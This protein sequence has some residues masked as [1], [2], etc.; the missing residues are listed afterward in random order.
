MDNDRVPDDTNDK[1]AQ[2]SAPADIRDEIISKARQSD[3]TGENVSDFAPPVPERDG[4]STIA[5]P[6]VS[7]WE[8]RF[9]L[10]GPDIRDMAT[11]CRQL[12]TLLDVGIP[13]LQA[14]TILTQRTTHPRLQKVIAAVARRV[15]EGGTLSSALREH[16][17]VFSFLFI[18]VIEV[19][20]SAGILEASAR[21]LAEILE[22]KARTR[23]RVVS[24]MMY[25]LAALSVCFA[26]IMLIVVW[27]V[28]R[29][30][31]IYKQLGDAPLPDATQR[32]IAISDFA[33]DYPLLY[34]P[35][36]I[37]AAVGLYIW[38]RTPS[39]K[40]AFDWLSLTAPI[41]SGVS[42]KVN[43]AR[44][45]RS[46]GSLVAAG[47]SL[48]EALEIT[49][50]SSEN[51]LMARRLR[52]VHDTLEQGGQLEEPLRQDAVIPPM[53]TDMIVIG[54]E[55]GAIDEMLLRVADIYDEEVDETLKGLTSIIEPALIVMLGL[56]VIFVALALLLPYFNL[57]SVLQ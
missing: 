2:E 55:A 37:A 40:S 45:T 1:G 7:I 53:V 34:V 4:G 36:L 56:V 3:A 43:V 52:A 11:F 39:G 49:A 16:P 20:E 10:F 30:Q 48:L 26:V 57:V 50:R 22:M 17:R 54:Y 19:G 18:S 25:P 15:E 13:L 47:V 35:L 44:F 27:A 14:L 42:V 41:I 29:F 6:R 12:S 8:R 28:P 9:T 51:S 33:R 23:K 31:D 46:L 5:P 32:L 38:G 24:A 21:R